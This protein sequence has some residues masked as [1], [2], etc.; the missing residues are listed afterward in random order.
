MHLVFNRGINVKLYIHCC[1]SAAMLAANAQA[2]TLDVAWPTHGWGASTP[3]EVG[4]D[5]AKLD[6]IDAEFAAGT[7]GYVDSFLIVRHGRIVYERTY[8]HDYVKFLKARTRRAG[9]TIITIRLA[10]FLS[11]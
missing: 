2:E 4:L 9:L 3:E 1:L 10:P 7:H 8:S 6:A 5:R 11:E